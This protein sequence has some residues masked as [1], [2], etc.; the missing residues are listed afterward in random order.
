[1]I[2]PTENDIGRKVIYCG[3]AGEREDGIVTSFNDAFVFVRYGS[4][5]TSAATKREQLEWLSG[6]DNRVFIHTTPRADACITASPCTKCSERRKR[7]IT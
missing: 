5:T 1:M 6:R 2:N 4:G 3:Y 7:P